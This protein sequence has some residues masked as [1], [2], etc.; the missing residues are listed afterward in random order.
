[1]IVRIHSTVDFLFSDNMIT[2]SILFVISPPPPHL[3]MFA[4]YPFLTT[5]ELPPGSNR[6]A[7]CRFYFW[8]EQ[9]KI[10]NVGRNVAWSNCSNV[11]LHRLIKLHNRLART[12]LDA[13]PRTHIIDL[14]QALSWKDLLT[15]WHNYRMCEV[16]KC[17]NNMAPRYL[18]DRFIMPSHSFKTRSKTNGKLCMSRTPNSNHGKRTFQYLGTVG[19]NNLNQQQREAK[20]LNI[21]KSFF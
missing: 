13:H 9:S 5:L 14:H 7:A 16:F 20:S 11:L 19:W 12:I 8:S 3:K 10:T 15:R 4:V 21:F 18:C 6:S 1:M 2:C 17:R